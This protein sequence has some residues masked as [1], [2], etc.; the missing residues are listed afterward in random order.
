MEVNINYRNSGTTWKL[1]RVE[2][3]AWRMRM[4]I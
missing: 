2:V 4:W 3:R 1:G